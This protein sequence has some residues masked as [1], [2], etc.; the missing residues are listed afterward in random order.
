M[1]NLYVA[2]ILAMFLFGNSARAENF[3]IPPECL[4]TPGTLLCRVIDDLVTN[5]EEYLRRVSETESLNPYATTPFYMMPRLA[6]ASGNLARANEI[7]Q[8]YHQRYLPRPVTDSV[9]DFDPVRE[10]VRY[11]VNIASD[12]LPSMDPADIPDP[13]QLE[14]QGAAEWMRIATARAL[15]ATGE[16]D[17]ARAAFM[18]IAEAMPYHGANLFVPWATAGFADDALASVTGLRLV[19]QARAKLNIAEG[20]AQRGDVEGVASILS[21]LPGGMPILG[22]AALAEAYRRSGDPETALAILDDTARSIETAHVGVRD[23]EAYRRI[24]IGYALLGDIEM[25]EYMMLRVIHDPSWAQY[26]WEMV[27]PFIA[28]HDFNLAMEL[29]GAA[30]TGSVAMTEL[31]I[32]ATRAGHGEETYGFAKGQ[33]SLIDRTLYIMAV[34]IG[35]IQSDT[36]PPDAVPCSTFSIASVY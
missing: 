36:V 4:E 18:M 28:C 11:S 7:I 19:P 12:P 26:H 10:V 2:C 13:V 31:L 23:H 16:T 8:D 27:A 6:A 3:E 32:S 15:A 9:F 33:E 25:T 5:T 1:R 20:L 22:Q 29:S 30:D 17:K 24:A 34:T 21:E 14:D 35:V